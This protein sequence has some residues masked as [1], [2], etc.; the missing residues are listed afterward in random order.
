M[1]LHSDYTTFQ[2]LVNLGAKVAVV[3][4]NGDTVIHSAIKHEKWLM[5]Q[6]LAETHGNLVNAA[7]VPAFQLMRT[8][9]QQQ[10]QV[11]AVD[12]RRFREIKERVTVLE[13]GLSRVAA[14][15]NMASGTCPICSRRFENPEW[16]EHV[17]IGCRGV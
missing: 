6:Y 14:G 15:R 3:D 8:P 16:A 5:V 4:P 17:R 7:G 12:T 11:I 13:F 10:Q 2:E 1:V 9:P